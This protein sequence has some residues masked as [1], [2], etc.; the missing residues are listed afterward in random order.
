VQGRR[1]APAKER[2]TEELA[3]PAK[4]WYNPPIDLRP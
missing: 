1:L 4:D 3:R 2:G